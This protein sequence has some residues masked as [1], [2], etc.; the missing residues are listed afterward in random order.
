MTRRA[1]SIRL[2]DLRR[3]A[4]LAGET[5]QTVMVEAPNGIVVRIAPPGAALPPVPSERE[6]AECDRAFGVGSSE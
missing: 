5:G 6:A 3:A 1:P 4:K 2:V